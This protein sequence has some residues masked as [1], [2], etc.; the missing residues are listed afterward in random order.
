MTPKIRSI[1]YSE[2]FAYTDIDAYISDLSL[3]TVWGDDPELDIPANVLA[4]RTVWLIR[5]WHIANDPVKQLLGGRTMA[6]AAE[7]LCMPYRTLQQWCSGD[8]PIAPH[9]RL[10][11][12]EML[13]YR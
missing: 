11:L 5:L 9:L 10:W 1:A 2:A 12:A 7:E 3:S 6:Q 4:D 13:G 8:R